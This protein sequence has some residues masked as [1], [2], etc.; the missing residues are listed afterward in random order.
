M[1]A[2]HEIFNAIRTDAMLRSQEEL[3]TVSIGIV[4]HGTGTERS[5]TSIN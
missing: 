4:Y 1:E 3:T 2:D 5:S